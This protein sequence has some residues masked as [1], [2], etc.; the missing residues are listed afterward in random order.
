MDPLT[1]LYEKLRE[2]AAPGTEIEPPSYEHWLKYWDD[3]VSEVG[4]L[5]NIQHWLSRGIAE[6]V[7]T[8]Q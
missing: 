6:R 4:N 1:N 5:R 3:Q 2:Q 8:R 7:G